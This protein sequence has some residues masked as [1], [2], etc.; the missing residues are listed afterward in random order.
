MTEQTLIYDDDTPDGRP[1]T[2]QEIDALLAGMTAADGT[3]YLDIFRD[4][5]TGH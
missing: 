3:P 5:Q 4:T 2:P 1:A